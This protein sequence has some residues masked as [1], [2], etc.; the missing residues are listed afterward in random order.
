MIKGISVYSNEG[1][2][3]EV[4]GYLKEAN[5]LGFNTVFTSVHIPELK[6]KEQLMH[7]FSLCEQVK[8]AKME[9][10]VDISGE[11]LAAIIKNKEYIEGFV[12]HPVMMRFDCR[13]ER[14]QILQAA[15]LLKVSALVLNASSLQEDKIVEIVK[16]IRERLPDI[17]LL[18]CH[19]FY[20]RVETGLTMEFLGK[21][22]KIF[23]QFG[24][25]VLSFLPSKAYP[26]GP[27]Y[28]GLVTVESHRQLS[29]EESALMLRHSTNCGGLIIADAYAEEEMLIKLLDVCNNEALKIRLEVVDSLSEGEKEILFLGEHQMRYDSG[30]MVL[31]VETSRSMAS[32]GKKIEPKGQRNRSMFDVTIDNEKYGRYSGELQIVLDDLPADARVNVVGY[33]AAGDQYKLEYIKKGKKFVFEVN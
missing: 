30:S 8:A 32:I 4:L 33:I 22:G 19:N 3:V 14:E 31:R 7:F 20:P 27:I 16:G 10:M 21:Q 17:Q 9:L 18:A 29:F 5:K 15:E 26:R 12:N 28:Q 25:P 1:I 6:M 24:I 13:Y 23:E 2:P 11:V